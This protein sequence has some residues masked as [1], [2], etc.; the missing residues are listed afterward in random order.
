[1][2]SDSRQSRVGREWSRWRWLCLL[3]CIGWAE[4]LQAQDISVQ[5]AIAQR[6]V[7]VGQPV[8]LT[9]SVNGSQTPDEPTW[10]RLD[11]IEVEPRGG[12]TRVQSFS[13]F[14]NGRIEER[15]FEG[16]VFKYELV[17][18]RPGVQVIPALGVV[19]NGQ[20][21]QSQPISVQVRAPEDRSEVR[22]Q[23]EVDNA[24]PYVGEAIE[25][26]ATMLLQA[27]IQNPV[28]RVPGIDGAF[29]VYD[30]PDA[31]RR[32]G[33]QTAIDFLNSRVPIERGQTTINGRSYD[34]FTA[35][36]LL[37]PLAEG[38][39]VLGPGTLSCQIVVRASR[40]LFDDDVLQAVT[41]P[42][43]TIQLNVRALPQ[44]GRP[45]NFT[46][47]IGS[48]QIA[49]SASTVDVNVGDPIT[50][51]IGVG[52]SGA[53]LRDPRIDL[54]GA[55]GFAG[56]FRVTEMRTEPKRQGNQLIYE[57]IIRPLDDSVTEIPAIELPYFDTETGAYAI[58]RTRPI[59]LRVRP[60]RIVTAGD[61]EGSGAGP[62]GSEVE[63]ADGGI[64]HNFSAAESLVDQRFVLT[65]AIRSPL[66]LATIAAPPALYFA[67]LLTL[68]V[69]RRGETDASSRRRRRALAT[70][71]RRLHE[72]AASS[73]GDR[74]GAALRQFLA[75]RFDRPAAGL[76][77]ADC[78]ELVRP[79]DASLAQR[80]QDLLEHCDALRYGGAGGHT[81]R[82]PQAEALAL[83]IELDQ[84]AE[85]RKGNG[86]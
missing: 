43:N 19:V 60:T 36:K 71:K 16:Y 67:A 47:L 25:L 82:D 44:E 2:R 81:D 8:Q 62:L 31:N 17:F 84:A 24:S 59:P 9:V 6:A 30:V 33:R 53:V 14:V 61:A 50:L 27:P 85:R 52:S 18:Q 37:V 10:P 4:P 54:A 57:Q 55:P 21:Y 64:A 41:V 34:T 3:M 32:G 1:M 15:R 26:R 42:S 48:Y 46:G 73:A 66:W 29:E 12:E 78:V 68:A 75:D 11:G 79:I 58:A 5:A 28:I 39:Q 40:S 22:L 70:A 49:A 63:D 86:A 74:A 51:T 38:E 72:H 83:L 7:Y 69:R 35:R 80:V 23:L 76:T 65:D 77:T 20:E 45:A 56:R 13:S